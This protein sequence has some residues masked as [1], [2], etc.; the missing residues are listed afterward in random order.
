LIELRKDGQESEQKSSL[1][2]VHY[3]YSSVSL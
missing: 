2:I 3:T 1:Y